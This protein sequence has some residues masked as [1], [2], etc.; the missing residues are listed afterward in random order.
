MCVCVYVCVY[1]CVCVCMQTGTPAQHHKV[2]MRKLSGRTGRSELGGYGLS[3]LDVGCVEKVLESDREGSRSRLQWAVSVE[4]GGQW[5]L[6]EL[7]GGG[8]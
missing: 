3:D 2:G 4:E 8:C 6:K 5:E 7:R 1:V